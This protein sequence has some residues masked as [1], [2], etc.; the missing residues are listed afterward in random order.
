MPHKDI[1]RALLCAVGLQ[2]VI[3]TAAQAADAPNT[4]NAPSKSTP[5]IPWDQLGAKAGADYHGEGLSVAATEGGARLHCVFQRLDGEATAEG[6]W[7]ASTVSNMVNDRFRVMATAV[8]R[9]VLERDSVAGAGPLPRTGTVTVAG[10]TVRFTRAGL[11][12]EYSASIDGVQQDFVVPEK[13][14]GEGQLE[15]QLAVSGARVEPT[16]HGAQLVLEQ[17]GRKIAYSRLHV[18]DATGKQLPSSIEVASEAAFRTPHSALALAVN[19]AGAVYPVRIDPTFSDANWLPLGSGLGGGYPYTSVSGLAVSGGTLYAGGQFTNAG[20]TAA[21]YIAQWNGSGWSPL[22]SGLGGFTYTSFSALAASGGA[23]YVGG[24]FT[25]AGGTNANY[26]AQWNGSSW[27]ALGSGISGYDPLVYALAASGGTLYAAGS[28]TYAGDNAVNNIAQWNGSTWSPLGSGISGFYVSA[29]AVS[30]GTLYAGGN[31]TTAGG[32]NANNIAQWDGSRWSPLGSGVNNTVSVLAVSGNM[33]YAGGQFTNAGGNA[34]YYIAQWNGSTWSPLGLGVNNDVY[35]LA[36]S[37]GTL[38]A[39]GQ[40]TTAGGTNANYIA[41][42]NGNTWSPLGSGMNN[43]VGALAVSGGTLYAGG[44]FTT[45]GGKGSAY[46]AEAIIRWPE[47]SSAP[48]RNTNGS[49]TL[50]LVTLPQSTNRLYAATNLT[51]PV[52]WQPIYTN[53]TGGLWQFTDTNASENRERIYRLST[54]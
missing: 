44:A 43:W 4:S 5:A 54:P 3:A 31:F 18:T 29:L 12:E 40:F 33:L 17:S 36:V 37:G 10:Q 50:N 39:G 53:V 19:D 48:V 49:F 24:W 21:N 41:Q 7:L 25:T 42:W 1:T 23:L 51:P 13:P 34:A 15:V 27:S 35:A 11:V 2:L 46:A 38:Y 9:K 32:T 26:I 28:F 6:L 52:V 47:F 14:P 20:G 45:A 16:A 30:G 8:G 22:G